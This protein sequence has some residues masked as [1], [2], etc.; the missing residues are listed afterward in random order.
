MD[1]FFNERFY[2]L[3]EAQRILN[4]SFDS[5]QKINKI[6]KV[7]N[8]INRLTGKTEKKDRKRIELKEKENIKCEFQSHSVNA[9]ILISSNLTIEE[10]Y[11]K[12]L[13]TNIKREVSKWKKQYLPL[14]RKNNFS[15]TERKAKAIISKIEIAKIDLRKRKKT[16]IKKLDILQMKL[17]NHLTKTK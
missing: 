8:F 16:G 7:H 3:I 2:K 11:K 4:M 6:L 10:I 1:S 13:T 12:E 9:L 5:T 14:F 15:I 17:E